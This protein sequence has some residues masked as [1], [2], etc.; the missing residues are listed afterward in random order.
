MDDKRI[1]ISTELFRRLCEAE[2]SIE[3]LKK[4]QYEHRYDRDGRIAVLDA[5]LSAFGE[6]GE[7]C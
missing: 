1:T 7:K 2:I 4:H 6:D 5:V 3:I